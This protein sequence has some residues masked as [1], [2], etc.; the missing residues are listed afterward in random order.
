MGRHPVYMAEFFLNIAI[1]ALLGILAGLGTGG[2]SLLLLWLTQVKD[3][4]PDEARGINLLFF[5]PGALIASFFRVRGNQIPPKKLISAIVPGC[6]A[7]AAASLLGKN[8]ETETLKLLFGI[9]LMAAG[10]RE[11]LYKPK[12]QRLRKAR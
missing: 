1:G 4:P 10:I 5:L 11:L 3:A 12:D 8:L 2:G 6:I 7:A 9:L